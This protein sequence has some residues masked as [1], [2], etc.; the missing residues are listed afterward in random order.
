MDYRY[1][2]G[3]YKQPAPKPTSLL[4]ITFMLQRLAILFFVLLI[5]ALIVTP[6]LGGCYQSYSVGERTGVITKLS[7]KGLVL[8]SWE[9]EMVL[10]GISDGSGT[11]GGTWQFSCRDAALAEKLRE[12]SESGQ[13]VTLEYN[14]WLVSPVSIETSHE[15]LSIK[16]TQ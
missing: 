1:N 10:G 4:P 2:A 11:F 5:G 3:R 8:K 6:V 9:G 16:N 14:E 12:V 13:R 7:Q 15:V